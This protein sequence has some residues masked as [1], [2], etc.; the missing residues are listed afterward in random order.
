MLALPQRG[1]QPQQMYSKVQEENGVNSVVII[2]LLRGDY[3]N[4]QIILARLVSF[5]RSAVTWCHGCRLRQEMV[6]DKT[7]LPDYDNIS[8]TL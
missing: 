4:C 7:V 6:T 3:C 1:S 8:V 2:L 5:L